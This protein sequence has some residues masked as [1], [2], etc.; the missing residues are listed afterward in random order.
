MASYCE[1]LLYSNESQGETTAGLTNEAQPTI[2]ATTDKGDIY[3]V[4]SDNSIGGHISHPD[5][6][7]AHALPYKV[8]VFH[9]SVDTQMPQHTT[10]AGSALQP[11]DEVDQDDQQY[12]E[13]QSSSQRNDENH[14]Y[15]EVK[16]EAKEKQS[17][18]MVSAVDKETAYHRESNIKGQAADVELF[19]DVMYSSHP[20]QNVATVSLRATQQ[21]SIDMVNT[22]ATLRKD[23]EGRSVA[24][25]TELVKFNTKEDEFDY[26]QPVVT[27][28]QLVNDEHLYD[29]ADQ[30]T[31]GQTKKQAT[32]LNQS[33]DIDCD[34]ILHNCQ[35][36]DPMYESN[37]QL[38]ANLQV[39]TTPSS[40]KV[41][42]TSVDTD[43]TESQENGLT[44][45][46]NPQLLLHHDGEAENYAD[47]PQYSDPTD[48]E[49]VG[50]TTDVLDNQD[51]GEANLAS[52]YNIFDDPTYGVGHTGSNRQ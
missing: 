23:S 17:N 49:S 44:T 14:L 12:R 4:I 13:N 41:D 35:F 30:L 33:A 19:D 21:L 8:A 16:R 6:P 51:K 42:P 22:E 28:G 2:Q 20:S 24:F 39:I 11:C 47:A 46:D 38:L 18:S 5:S 45:Q 9:G 25:H 40:M 52:I 7:S 15:D 37:P 34:P 10:D 26:A 48:L 1:C 27:T 50:N 29:N 43:V 31:K 32:L 36:D 3:S